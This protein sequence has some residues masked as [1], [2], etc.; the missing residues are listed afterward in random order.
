MP[1][2][3]RAIIKKYRW[4]FSPDDFM[5]MAQEIEDAYQTRD[6]HLGDDFDTRNWLVFRDWLRSVASG[7]TAFPPIPTAEG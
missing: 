1:C 6:R 3:V 4:V 5:V 7:V 2:L